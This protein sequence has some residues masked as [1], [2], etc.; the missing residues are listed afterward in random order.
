MQFDRDKFAEA[1]G[2]TFVIKSADGRTLDLELKEVSEIRERP[3]QQSFSIVFLVPESFTVEQGLY[4][5]EHESLGGMQL[6]I[7][8]VGM[9]DSRMMLEAVFNTLR[10]S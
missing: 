2:S 5:I 10:E 3:H 9:N 7:V 1:L 4:D 8:P 6:F